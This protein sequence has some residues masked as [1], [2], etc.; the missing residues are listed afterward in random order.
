MEEV[1]GLASLADSSMSGGN[2]SRYVSR[3]GEAEVVEEDYIDDDYDNYDDEF[4]PGPED[5]SEEVV[6]EVGDVRASVHSVKS[7]TKG[8]AGLQYEDDIIEEDLAA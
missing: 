7:S 6:D 2:K 4:E 5:L 3:A 8:K 1:E